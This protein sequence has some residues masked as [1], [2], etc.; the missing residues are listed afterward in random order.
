MCKTHFGQP[1]NAPDIRSM[2]ENNYLVSARKYR[3]QDWDSVV[4]QSGITQTL[5][6]AISLGTIAQAY[7][8]CGPRGV[9]KTTSARI[10]ARAINGFEPDDDAMAF[11]VFE[12]DAA[13]NNKVEDIR[14]IVEQVRIP[15]QYGTY[16]VYIIDEV[17]M[18]S[19]AA[20]NAFLKTLEEPPPHAVFILATTE[21][22]KILPTILS[23]CQIFDF[24]RIT[25]PDMVLHL[26]E[27][28]IKEGVKTTPEAL[29]VI[30]AKADG[31]LRDALSMFDQLI[32]FAGKDL[33]YDIVTEQLHVLDHDVYFEVLDFALNSNIP[34]SLLLFDNVLARGFDAHHFLSGL[35][36]HLRSLMVCRDERTLKLMEATPEVKAKFSEQAANAD[37]H[38]IVDA[39]SITNEADT[40]YRMSQ[41]QRLLVELA[42][43]K[44]CSLKGP[45]NS[46]NQKPLPSAEKKKS[47]NEL[48]PPSNLK[49]IAQKE[50][51][52]IEPV[53]AEVVQA[54]VVQA[55]I[56]QENLIQ[57]V[58]I[59]VIDKIEEPVQVKPVQ[60]KPISS[61]QV[62]S[63][64]T[65]SKKIVS[66]GL[67]GG[68]MK[69]AGKSKNLA[70]TIDSSSK[71]DEN[72]VDESWSE[73][74][75]IDKV[76]AAWDLFVE[77]HRISKR[78]SL[79]STL[80]MC[81]L[82]LKDNVVVFN[83]LNSLQEEQLN[84]ERADLLF[85]LRKTVK[86]ALLELS[87]EIIKSEDGN[88][89]PKVFLT[90]KE[91]YMEMIKKNP[92][93]DELRKRLDLDLG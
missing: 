61:V 18:L 52:P 28:A 10:F 76:K 78:V 24:H 3:P 73:E 45:S 91:R 47:F 6:K 4:G 83:V 9:G 64:V 81:E 92:N 42:V 25:V 88:D 48:I 87:I 39:L 2:S 16:K 8:F 67:R 23:R 1:L 84:D 13:S 68:G 69:L 86:N 43:M 37:L 89:E 49:K 21:K 90:D 26:Q 93:L 59:E 12:L 74:V 70:E 51:V 54:D 33:T 19:Q 5:Q 34:D 20:F 35:G 53:Q 11:N 72:E 55:D 63:A 14:S 44:I 27:I 66:G 56:V 46:D 65:K 15:P 77:G 60:V 17:H 38:F 57:D 85:H 41:H 32:A 30:A 75:T 80:T 22:H 7:L 29:H 79:V 62:E 50:P 40:Q 58:G 31:A 82:D 71:I 36:N